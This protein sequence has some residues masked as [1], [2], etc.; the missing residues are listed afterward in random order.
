MD[1]AYAG[2]LEATNEVRL[3]RLLE[4]HDGRG[5]EMEVRLEGIGDL[6]DEALKRKP[7]HECKG[8]LG[9]SAQAA[10]DTDANAASQAC[11]DG[12]SENLAD[13]QIVVTYLRSDFRIVRSWSHTYD[14]TQDESDRGHIPTTRRLM[15]R[16][17]ES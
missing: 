8:Y 16:I 1:R 2:V 15:G 13:W 17:V 11:I 6:A 12:P 5:L 4:R 3:R 14:P 7:A 9:G 10:S